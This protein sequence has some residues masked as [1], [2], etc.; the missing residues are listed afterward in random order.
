M[1]AS[2]QWIGRRV[3]SK[4]SRVFSSVTHFDE[5]HVVL[6]QVSLVRHSVFYFWFTYTC[7][8]YHFFELCFVI[9][10]V[11]DTMTKYAGSYLLYYLFRWL[12][13]CYTEAKC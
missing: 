10:F 4:M 1:F 6:W 2:V 8:F 3:V 11:Y 12:L 5:V 13:A 9:G 7:L